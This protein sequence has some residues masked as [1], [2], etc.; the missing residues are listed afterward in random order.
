M[1]ENFIMV[2][3]GKSFAHYYYNATRVRTF[4]TLYNDKQKLLTFVFQAEFVDRIGYEYI[5]STPAPYFQWPP[6]A[7]PILSKRK[8]NQSNSSSYDFIAS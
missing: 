3:Q 6:I 2:H 8:C 7:Q 1:T 4:E 5:T